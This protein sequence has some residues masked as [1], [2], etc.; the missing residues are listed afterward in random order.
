MNF[1]DILSLV[2][3]FFWRVAIWVIHSQNTPKI[4]PDGR[5]MLFLFGIDFRQ[6]P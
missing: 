1:E 3:F 6:Q 5:F 4:A 2:M